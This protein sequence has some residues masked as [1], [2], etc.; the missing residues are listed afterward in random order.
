MVGRSMTLLL[1]AKDLELK[2]EGIKKDIALDW[3]A[4][5][6]VIETSQAVQAFVQV[7]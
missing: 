6:L 1:E 4:A 2:L 7:R 5:P 3:D